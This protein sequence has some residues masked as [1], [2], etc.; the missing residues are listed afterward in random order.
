MEV[1]SEIPSG[2]LTCKVDG[3]ETGILEISPESL[4]VRLPSKLEEKTELEVFYYDF[5]NCTYRSL[6]YPEVFWESVPTKKE[7]ERFFKCYRTRTK[8]VQWQEMFSFVVQQYY[9]YIL[10]KTKS[11]G[12]EFS[13][14]LVGYPEEKDE[15]FDEDYFS[16]KA[17]IQEEL[18]G[19]HLI[20]AICQMD[21]EL[22]IS[23]ENPRSFQMFLDEKLEENMP[24]G[25]F[26]KAERLYIGNPFCHHL[27]PEKQQ[28][29]QIL[30]KAYE[31]NWKVT[32]HF[33]YVRESW[34]AETEKIVNEVYFW[35]RKKELSLEMVVNDWGM[36]ELLCGKEDYI[37]PVFGTLLNKRR[38]D[39]RYQYKKSSKEQKQLFM[40]TPFEYK[41]YTDFL[42]K[43]G[44]R[45]L[46]FESGG[47]E[48]VLPKQKEQG[49]N[50]GISMHLPLYQT[51]TSQYCPLY[52]LCTTQER[53]RQKEVKVCPKFCEQYAYIYAKHLHM[54]GR[55]N[56]IIAADVNISKEELEQYQK[57]GMDRI[58]WNFL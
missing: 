36:F 38:K 3:E 4:L 53:G 35:C 49:E 31:R 41:E 15:T 26:E 29:Y 17:R 5:K 7:E 47:Y 27:F 8:D 54:A 22:A 1:V 13:K 42:Q 39:P 33:T 45:R 9:H 19:N 55:Y 58:V 52:A 18:K 2:L 43:C 11:V 20:E 25:L 37:T 40:E 51:N 57:Q 48:V 10:L 24:A 6:K 56:S 28:L 46:E 21:T 23:L 50:F 44:V 14:E 30:E 12:N 16:W 34:R 32:L